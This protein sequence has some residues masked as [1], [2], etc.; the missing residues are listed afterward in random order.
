LRFVNFVDKRQYKLKRCRF[1]YRSATES[2]QH[3]NKTPKTTV[4]YIYIFLYIDKRHR[5]VVVTARV[6]VNTVNAAA[7]ASR[8]SDNLD[9]I[10]LRNQLSTEPD[11]HIYQTPRRQQQQQATVTSSLWWIDEMQM[12][13]TLECSRRSV[14]YRWSF[15]ET[16]IFCSET[17]SG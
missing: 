17:A 8:A 13:S 3:F 2:L 11:V 4:F 12:N 1:S 9:D 6:V 7:P 14:Y 15:A 16:G 10:L 5:C